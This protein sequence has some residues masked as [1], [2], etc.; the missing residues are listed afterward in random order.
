MSTPFNEVIMSLAVA[1]IFEERF[2]IGKTVAVSTY[3]EATLMAEEWVKQIANRP[4]T[5]EEQHCFAETNYLLLR[6]PDVEEG[7]SVA[8]QLIEIEA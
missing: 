1:V 8:V 7:K 3:E 4:I 6:P 5:S 2:E